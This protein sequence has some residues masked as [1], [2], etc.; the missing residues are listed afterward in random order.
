MMSFSRIEKTSTRD[1]QV[2]SSPTPQLTE[3]PAQRQ[4]TLKWNSSGELSA[5]DLLRVLERLTKPELTEC[6]IADD[7]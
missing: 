1:Q 7:G 3:L 4:T 5:V 2:S 6:S